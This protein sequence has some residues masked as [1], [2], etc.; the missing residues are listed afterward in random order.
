MLKYG[1][2]DSGGCGGKKKQSNVNVTIGSCLDSSFPSLSDVAGTIHSQDVGLKK[3]NTINVGSTSQVDEGTA[4]PTTHVPS[5]TADATS[6]LGNASTPNEG[7]HESVVKEIP[8]SYANKLSPTSLT[9]ADLQKLD[10]NL[11]NNYDY[12]NW[13]PLVK[14]HDVLLAAYTSDGLSLIAMKVSTPIMLD[15]YMNSMC[16]KSWGR[17][18]YARILIEIDA[19]NNFSDNLFMVVP[20]LEGTGYTKETI[21]ME[22]EW[23]PHHCSICLIFGHLLDDCPK[24]LTQ[25][26]NMMD[27]GKIGSYGADDNRFIS[28]K[29]KKLR[30]NNGGNKNFKPISVKPKTQYHPKAKQLTEGA[31]HK[32]T[33]SFGKKNVFDNEETCLLMDDGKPLEKVDYL[34]NQFSEDEV[35]SVDNEMESYLA[36]KLWGVG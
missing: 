16:L 20:K 13:L 6:A 8:S 10:A 21:H 2:L 1:F 24:A 5:G 14:F 4:I 30:G 9:K 12:N 19:C 36:S 35:E 29:K 31:G 11:P 27:K 34:G 33:P 15:S 3:G 17:S 23:E 32:T 22:Y 28:V 26:V 7:G 25:V 18:I